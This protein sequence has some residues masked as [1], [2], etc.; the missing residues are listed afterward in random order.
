[1]DRS[2]DPGLGGVLTHLETAMHRRMELS[3]MM[4]DLESNGAFV[5]EYLMNVGC[6]RRRRDVG[7]RLCD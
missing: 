2:L 6:I 3:R 1:M 4:R 5:G 7:W